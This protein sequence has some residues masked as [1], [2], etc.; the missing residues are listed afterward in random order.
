M[1]QG[2][3]TLAI[4]SPFSG[5]GIRDLSGLHISGVAPV[6]IA[7]RW[8]GQH[9]SCNR[10]HKT[11]QHPREVLTFSPINLDVGGAD[12]LPDFGSRYLLS[13]RAVLLQ[14]EKSLDG[15]GS[16]AFVR[17]VIGT[18]RPQEVLHKAVCPIRI[19]IVRLRIF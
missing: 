18:S 15:V 11:L 17:E 3:R 1:A 2:S 7:Q 8:P 4:R 19:T 9:G 16:G 14:R 13:L 5:S 10:G 6:S 12:S